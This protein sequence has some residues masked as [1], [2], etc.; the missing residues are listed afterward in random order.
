MAEYAFTAMDGETFGHHRPGLEKLLFEI[1]TEPSL[2]TV[3]ISEL[4]SLFPKR[5]LTKPEDSTWALMPAD[6]AKKEPFSRWADP[7][8][9]IHVWQWRLT[10]LAL[11]VISGK[12]RPKSQKSFGCRSSF[13]PILV[14]VGAALVE[15]GND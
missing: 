11:K 6:L 4:I 8:N 7:E 9:K 10:Q 3:T 1:S 12:K 14:G 2:K 13:R 15:L 5:E